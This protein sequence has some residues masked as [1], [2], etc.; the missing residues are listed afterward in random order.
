MSKYLPRKPHADSLR[1][2]ARQLLREHGAGRPEAL[3]RM[4]AHSSASRTAEFTL[5]SAQRV[6]AREHGFK[7]WADLM[8][9]VQVLRRADSDLLPAVDAAQQRSQPLHVL[10]RHHTV[11]EIV[12]V[13]E[14]HCG[15][16]PLTLGELG[17]DRRIST[18]LSRL[19]EASLVAGSANELGFLVMYE[20][21]DRP[22]GPWAFDDLLARVHAFVNMPLLDD[23][24]P[25]TISGW[26]EDRGEARDLISM[27]LPEVYALYGSMT[28]HRF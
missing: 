17:E 20:R 2:Q 22:E 27:H 19:T 18:W 8:E 16:E 24:S 21:L 5:Q 1:A 14:A 3:E 12:G 10:V 15:R 26:D 28:D 4:R 9:A 6:L 11:A 23:T 7:C 13:I 25:L